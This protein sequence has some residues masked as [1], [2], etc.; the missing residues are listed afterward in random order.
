MAP[1]PA[2]WI[3]VSGGKG[4]QYVIPQNAADEETEEPVDMGFEEEVDELVDVEVEGGEQEEIYDEE[5]E[6][7]KKEEGLQDF[8][9]AMEMDMA[10]F[11][12]VEAWEGGR[13]SCGM[14][15][16]A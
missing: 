14:Q 2:K 10:A 6:E 13:R 4:Q 9:D 11:A 16:T 5:E 12:G 3:R 1:Q 15:P 7:R 8:N